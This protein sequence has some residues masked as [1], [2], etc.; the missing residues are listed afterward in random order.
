[1]TVAQG[2]MDDID[3]FIEVLCDDSLMDQAARKALNDL[4]VTR[5]DLAISGA[6]RSITANALKIYRDLIMD[7]CGLT[8]ESLEEVVK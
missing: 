4:W 5:S 2:L 7:K 8:V 3:K 1:M 6:P